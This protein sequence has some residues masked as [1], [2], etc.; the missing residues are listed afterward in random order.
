MVLLALWMVALGGC[1]FACVCVCACAYMCVCEL[2]LDFEGKHFSV[3]VCCYLHVH[4]GSLLR[5]FLFLLSCLTIPVICLCV[6]V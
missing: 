6:S 1:A 3:C 4:D 2:F 5:N